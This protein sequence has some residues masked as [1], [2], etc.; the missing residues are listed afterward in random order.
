M[1][2]QTVKYPLR[3]PM[4]AMKK[5]ISALITLKMKSFHSTFILRKK[6]I[7]ILLPEKTFYSAYYVINCGFFQSETFN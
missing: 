7:I 3:F 5:K 1:Q 6:I 4:I 2:S